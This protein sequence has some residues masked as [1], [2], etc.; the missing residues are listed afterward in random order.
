VPEQSQEPLQTPDVMILN[1]ERIE[2]PLFQISETEKD[3]LLN[4]FSFLDF[5]A[6]KKMSERNFENL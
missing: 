3:R 1:D 4:L 2:L 6:H 5:D